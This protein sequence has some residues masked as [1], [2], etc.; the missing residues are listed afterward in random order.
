MALWYWDGYQYYASCI[1]ILSVTS[2]TTSLVDTLRNLKSIRKMA[3]YSCSV[4]V[5]R[6]GN[7]NDLTEVD[8]SDL[9]PGDVIEIPEMTSMPCDLALL[10][11]SCIVNESM[12]TGESIPVIKNAIPFINDVYDPVVDQKYTLY[13]GTKVIQTRKFGNSKVLGLVIRTAFV[14]TK[15]NLVRDILYP[16]PNKFKFYQDSLKFIFG[17]GLLAVVG[18][19]ATLPFMLS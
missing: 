11:G 1:L 3:L 5:M 16:K 4:K 2:A 17:M 10:T 15:G 18:F 14:T 8:S 6:G 13:G 12:L 7:E 9:V 19:L